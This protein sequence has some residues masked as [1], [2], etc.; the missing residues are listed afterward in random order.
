L[1]QQPWSAQ[2][3][4]VGSRRE[5]GVVDGENNIS[6][7]VGQRGVR[8]YHPNR[9]IMAHWGEREPLPHFES[10]P[11]EAEAP[12]RDSRRVTCRS[13]SDMGAKIYAQWGLKSDPKPAML[14]S[15]LE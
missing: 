2:E 4:A 6:V 7:I 13:R 5:H 14:Q 11:L 8:A 1:A 12:P 3:S 10:N 15:L 9:V